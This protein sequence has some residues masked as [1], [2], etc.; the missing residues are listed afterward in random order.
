[1]KR[2]LTDLLVFAFISIVVIFSFGEVVGNFIQKTGNNVLNNADYKVNEA[3][4]RSKQR[5]RTKHLVIGESVGNQLYGQCTDSIVFSLTATVAITDVGEYLLLAKFLD[6]NKDQL[7]EDVV[8]IY[9]PFC[10]N[11]TLT[12]GLVYS[13]FVKN[14]YNDDYIRYMDEELIEHIKKFPLATLCKYKVYQYSPYIP[15]V[16]QV[17]QEKGE[18]ISPIQFNYLRKI[19]NLCKKK[20]VGFK[21][22]A[23]PIRE[24]R[25]SDVASIR[26]SDNSFTNSAFSGYFESLRYLPDSNYSDMNHMKS[27]FIPDDYL[28]LY[29]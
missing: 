25:K 17:T 21:L 26:E 16:E 13:T 27:A 24:S 3:I 19:H 1:M 11:N 9:N 2:F 22:T 28:N 23:G 5:I 12:G 14:F 8:M 6:V 29:K 4:M 7:P 15:D 10:W 18:G 20:G